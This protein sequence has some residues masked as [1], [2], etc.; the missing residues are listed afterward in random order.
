MSFQ[1]FVFLTK[2]VQGSGFEAPFL[3]EIYLLQKNM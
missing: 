1:N 2:L 3:K